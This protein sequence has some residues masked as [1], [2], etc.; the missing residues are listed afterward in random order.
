MNCLRR[1]TLLVCAAVLVTASV[2]V[3][4]QGPPPNRL[5]L[6]ERVGLPP[7]LPMSELDVSKLTPEERKRLE[8]MQER[9]L[10][11]DATFSDFL[12]LW[13]EPQPYPKDVI[14]RIDENHAYPHPA[15]SWKMV[16]VKEDEDTV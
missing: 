15:A 14:L 6:D 10:P 7:E 8:R 3:A 9:K 13:L 5:P 2:A 11:E 1:L 4:Q 12:A 16:I